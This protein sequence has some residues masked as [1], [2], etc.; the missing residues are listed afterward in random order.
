MQL[1]RKADGAQPFLDERGER[2]F[3]LLGAGEALGGLKNH[4]MI[5]LE[6]EP[7]AVSPQVPHFHRQ[8]EE[9]Y[10]ILSGV[11]D[12]FVDDVAYQLETGDIAVALAGEKHQIKATGDSKLVALAV[13]VPGFNPEDVFES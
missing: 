8:S 6:L 1:V 10:V 13:M 2:I 12:F 4:S 7:G 3:E 9:T 11:A 5:R